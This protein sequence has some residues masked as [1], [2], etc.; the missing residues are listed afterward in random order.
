MSD[1]LLSLISAVRVPGG[2]ISLI[3]ICCEGARWL[4]VT[5]M[6]AVRVSDGLLSLLSAVRVPNGLTVTYMCLL[7]AC[8]MTYCHICC[9]DASVRTPLRFSERHLL[10]LLSASEKGKNAQITKLGKRDNYMDCMD[11]VM[12]SFV[13]LIKKIKSLVY[14]SQGSY[15][16]Q[17]DF[18]NWLADG[19]TTG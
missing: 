8:Q 5:Y 11:P 4:T 2:L 13:L 12:Y 17:L 9:E 19:S 1:G 6:S 16:G 14:S 7:W 18:C 3:C 10:S 15:T